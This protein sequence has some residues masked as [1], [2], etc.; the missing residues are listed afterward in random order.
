[1]AASR[2][3]YEVLRDFLKAAA[4]TWA[5]AWG[6]PT[7]MVTRA[8]VLKA[9]LRIAFD[10]GREDAAPVE[11]RIARWTA[12]LAPWRELRSQSRVDGFYE[13]FPAKGD[14]ER[15]EKVRKALSQAAGIEPA[16]R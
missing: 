12:R 13:R 3:R 15:V 2:E 9:M 14:V 4:A 16:R 10:L 6:A 7:S 5:E 8:V 1:V 11:G